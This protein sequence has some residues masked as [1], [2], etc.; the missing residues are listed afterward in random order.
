[1]RR[2]DGGVLKLVARKSI[3][4]QRMICVC[5]CV[6][7]IYVCNVRIHR[8]E[9]EAI[10][11]LER[12][13]CEKVRVHAFQRPAV[14]PKNRQNHAGRGSKSSRDHTPLLRR[15]DE[16]ESDQRRADNGMETSLI[17]LREYL[18]KVISPSFSSSAC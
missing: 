16:E 1:M 2:I 9:N 3:K 15:C 10:T 8:L 6:V 13:L 7:H 14:H 11:C 4:P 17:A 18:S 12:A 5:V